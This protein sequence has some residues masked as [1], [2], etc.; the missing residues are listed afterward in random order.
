MTRPA[1]DGRTS[2]GAS[3]LDADQAALRT[4]GRRVAAIVL[5]RGA[6]PETALALARAADSAAARGT[7]LTDIAGELHLEVA[8]LIGTDRARP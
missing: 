8:A 3:L 5:A 7:P 2:T 1:L 6:S 4:L